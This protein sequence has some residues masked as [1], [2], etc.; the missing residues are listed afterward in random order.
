MGGAGA[1]TMIELGAGTA[2]K[3][4]LLLRAA[5]RRQ[6]AVDYVPIDVSETALAAAKEHIE[7]EIPGVRV[8]R[9]WPTTRK[10]SRRF[11]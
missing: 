8:L 10:V 7:A 4:G 6:G 11:L 3:T 2:A 5:V 1:L 9:A